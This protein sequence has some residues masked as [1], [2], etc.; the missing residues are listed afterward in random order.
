MQWGQFIFMKNFKKYFKN[1]V[2]SWG[3]FF[4][5]F[6]AAGCSKDNKQ[7][8]YFD[9][10]GNIETAS[11]RLSPKSRNPAWMPKQSESIEVLDSVD[12]KGSGSWKLAKAEGGENYIEYS[13]NNKSESIFPLSSF[14]AT[15]AIIDMKIK[16]AN[17]G[18][19]KKND[20]ELLNTLLK[21]NK[22]E[23]MATMNA[24]GIKTA[25]GNWVFNENTLTEKSGP[26]QKYFTQEMLSKNPK[27]LLFETKPFFEGIIQ[28]EISFEEQYSEGGF[29]ISLAKSTKE[30]FFI[31]VDS[32]GTLFISDTSGDEGRRYMNHIKLPGEAFRKI[33]RNSRVKFTVF[34]LRNYLVI[35][36]ELNEDKFNITIP[37]KDLYNHSVGHQVKLE[38]NNIYFG[39]ARG[40]GGMVKFRN[41]K[42]KNHVNLPKEP[43]SVFPEAGVI[44][45][46]SGRSGYL[47]KLSGKGE[48]SLSVFKNGNNAAPII[49]KILEEKPAYS[50]WYLLKIIKWKN[51]LA[52]FLDGTLQMYLP[53][54]GNDLTGTSAGLYVNNLEK[55]F[56]TFSYNKNLHFKSKN[57]ILKMARVI[58]EQKLHIDFNIMYEN[59][60]I[61]LSPPFE[62]Y[63]K[64][65]RIE[66]DTRSSL[67][68]PEPGSISYDVLVPELGVLLFS[69]GL[70]PQVW[71][72]EGY[73]H[74]FKIIIEKE[75]KDKKEIFE[76]KIDPLDMS[77][78]KWHEQKIDLSS[79]GGQK[80]K[81]TFETKRLNESE[82]L[83]MNFAIWGNPAI[84]TP[85]KK[86]DL[87][88]ILIS[89]DTLRPDHLSSYGYPKLTSPFI[90]SLAGEG[91][92]F[93]NAISQA[94]W[95]LPSHGSIFTSLYP[96]SHGLGMDLALK[97][98]DHV[99][100]LPSNVKTLAEVLKDNGYFTAS[101][102]G[103]GNV[104]A[105]FG[106]SQGFYSY[107][108]RWR[109][110]NESYDELSKW[111][112]ENRKFK[113]HLFF[114][115]W[116]VH[117]YTRT[118][119]KYY[120]VNIPQ[121][122]HKEYIS[123]QY[124]SSIK[125][126]DKFI[127][128]LIYKL[129]ELN[130]RENTLIVLT[131]DHG[132]EFY[133]HDY[134]GHALYLYD[135]LIKVP[136]IFHLPG[137]IP[138]NKSINRQVMLIDVYPTIL[139]LL[140]I[141]IPEQ[142]QGRSFLASL[143]GKKGEDVD[144]RSFVFSEEHYHV[145]RTAARTNEKKFILRKAM[146]NKASISKYKKFSLPKS[147]EKDE[148]LL[149]SLRQDPGEQKNIVETLNSN[150]L[151]ELDKEIKFFEK[152]NE[153]NYKKFRK[154]KIGKSRI[155]K[156]TKERLQGLGYVN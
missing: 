143:K 57:E 32:D 100:L 74:R 144:E 111:I 12:D 86:N 119:N 25:Y 91:I 47:L 156:F 46:Y 24:A 149:F 148:K 90:D 7:P 27:Y 42:Y 128:M 22:P 17:P 153:M 123:A 89:I 106:F 93:K 84:F 40:T 110:I 73:I 132:E 63:V 103:G 76:A 28:T 135:T 35:Y 95:T 137:I 64:K 78:K 37:F 85:R 77:N 142:A 53:L 2:Y 129:K 125:Y 154:G 140:Q 126:M 116:D 107:N 115:V 83:S 141:K 121:E 81:I 15:D 113:F 104:S 62:K 105:D 23:D 114:H 44:F 108:E 102:N 70:A 133:E 101:F 20:K 155:S 112:S 136:L 96:S 39:L 34:L 3:C 61:N 59:N 8:A 131:S 6:A 146:T 55:G 49:T 38:D 10:V 51:H 14:Q 56:F 48:L 5:I 41:I 45:N 88:V 127:G 145:K 80:V 87:N 54:K 109:Y 71:N 43:E 66:G 124:D 11:I 19:V 139:D 99:E 151:N 29:F 1:I 65:V 36:I 138:S 18:E 33:K 68:L 69:Y 82:T 60:D 58:E 21:H 150:S 117:D 122:D 147:Y 16:I 26:E 134:N 30:G 97:Y 120:N 9:F 72:K 31:T 75:D 52:V 152:T 79:Y 130:L 98:K 67:Y 13:N 4:L 50:Q 118:R 94:P 92:L